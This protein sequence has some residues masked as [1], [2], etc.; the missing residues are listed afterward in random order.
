MRIFKKLSDKDCQMNASEVEVYS[1]GEECEKQIFVKKPIFWCFLAVFFLLNS[2]LSFLIEPAYGSSDVMWKS[3][4]HEEE[5]DTIF[6]GSS[7]CSAS[8]DPNIFNEKLGVKSYNMGTPMQSLTQNITAVETA[9]EEHEIKNI[10]IG[11][12]FF[13]LQ[14]E[15]HEPA[16]LTFEK[17]LARNKGGMKG[18]L[19]SMEYVFGESAREKEQSIN[20][21]FPWIYNKEEY[22][23]AYIKK[24]VATKKEML[25][26]QMK[27]ETE[28]LGLSE[29]KGYGPYYTYLDYT[30]IGDNNSY[31]M[32][33]QTLRE[34]QLQEFDKL[35]SICQKSGA[36]VLVVNT[37]HPDFDVKACR[38]VYQMN[39]EILQNICEKYDVEYYDFSLVKAELFEKKDNYFADFEH[40]NYEGSQAF[41]EM[42]CE[43]MQK[44]QNGENMQ[45][46]FYSVEEYMEK[47]N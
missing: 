23:L 13:V 30:Q 29:T 44:W 28:G 33:Q 22:S 19:E 42:L 15:A 31:V 26:A 17:E 5:I 1:K 35:L 39:T 45:M 10:I 9:L 12:G 36:D 25:S 24:N 3:F 40:L 6:V 32:Y 14:E 21:W 38:E 16:A 46:Y 11:I 2:F 34:E 8:F 7:L 47:M 20:Y 4:F 41:S 37:P 18:F 43:F 27:A